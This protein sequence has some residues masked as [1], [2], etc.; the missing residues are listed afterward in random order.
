MVV[1]SHNFR[2]ESPDGDSRPLQ[3]AET[4][5]QR[6][7]AGCSDATPGVGVAIPASPQSSSTRHLLALA[8]DVEERLVVRE[9]LARARGVWVG[10]V[11]TA[12]QD[13]A[14]ILQCGPQS[15]RIDDDGVGRGRVDRDLVGDA[16]LIKRL[17]QEVVGHVDEKLHRPTSAGTLKRLQLTT[18][19]MQSFGINVEDGV[20]DRIEDRRVRTTDDGSRE[21]ASRSEVANHLLRLGLVAAEAL[22]D[23]DFDV[24]GDRAREAMVRQAV[25][26][27]VRAEEDAE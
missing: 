4:A 14:G 21:I 15:E 10:D 26:D 24:P 18:R 19:R 20:A 23:A 27:Q 13:V 8:A 2:R 7:T 1:C 5:L 3:P 25:V 17:Q 11:V 9:V 22:D 16:G 12:G 6:E